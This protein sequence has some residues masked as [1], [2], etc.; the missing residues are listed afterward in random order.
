[1]KIIKIFYFIVE[2]FEIESTKSLHSLCERFFGIHFSSFI[3]DFLD[4]N[5][6]VLNRNFSLGIKKLSESDK[7]NE[8]GE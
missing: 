5:I 8:Y 3:T 4:V 1:M 7:F 2:S 6:D